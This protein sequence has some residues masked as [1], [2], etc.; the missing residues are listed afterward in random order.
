MEELLD[1]VCLPLDTCSKLQMALGAYWPGSGLV[2]LLR[3][4]AWGPGLSKEDRRLI[5]IP[6]SKLLMPSGVLPE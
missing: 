6:A 3:S 4:Q 2:Y 5:R 1:S